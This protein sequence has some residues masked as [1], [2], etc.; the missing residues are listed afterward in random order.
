MIA[1]TLF[2]F[3][4]L[5]TMAMAAT[6]KQRKTKKWEK[7]MSQYHSDWL[8]HGCYVLEKRMTTSGSLLASLVNQNTSSCALACTKTLQ[9]DAFSVDKRHRCRLQKA[10]KIRKVNKGTAGF[11]PKSKLTIYVCFLWFLRRDYYDSSNCQFRQ[12]MEISRESQVN[13]PTL[14]SGA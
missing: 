7:R 3:A 5:H 12:A 8:E 11:C 6:C 4:V 13:L 9:C 2:G 1:K 14:H 10:G